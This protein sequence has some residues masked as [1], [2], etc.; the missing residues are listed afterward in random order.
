MRYNTTPLPKSEIEIRVEITPE[1]MTRAGEK[2]LEEAISTTEIDGFRKGK[3]PKELAR[4]KIGETALS[5]RAVLETIQNSYQKIIKELQYKEGPNF[6]PIGAPRVDV[7]K[8]VAGGELEYTA[9]LSILPQLELP[10]YKEIAKKI[11]SEKHST[12]VSEKELEES[13]LWLRKS[14]AQE[15]TVARG[16]KKGDRV[17]IDFEAKVGGAPLER[18]LSKNHPIIIGEDR[19]MPGFEEQLLGMKPGEKKT[20]SIVTPADYVE[21]PLRGK[22]I[23]F[24]V[25]MNLVQERIVPDESDEFAAGIGNF[26]NINDLKTNI[27]EGMLAEKEGK[28]NERVRIRIIDAIAEKTTAEIP[29]ILIERELEKMMAELKSGVEQMGL[30]WTAY[31]ANIKKNEEELRNGWLKDAGRRVKIALVL[32]KIAKI[33]KLEPSDAEIQEAANKTIS[34]MGMDEEELKKIDREAFLEYNTVIA[35]NEKVF[36]FLENIN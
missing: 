36:R 7:K 32:R 24:T 4:Q 9:R 16:A 12:E 30:D 18:G 25:T 28:E 14:R 3:A 6:E 33:E 8:Y 23:D 35:R 21:Q 27:R 22:T 1:E 2:A 13:L 34:Q 15:I 29:D 11:L 19:F 5:K 17:E 10:D 20:F 26:K 31:L